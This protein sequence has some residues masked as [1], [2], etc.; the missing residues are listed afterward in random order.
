MKG[1]VIAQEVDS[2]IK[3]QS[4]L[5]LD[6]FAIRIGILSILLL[7]LYYPMIM[8]L[9][10][11]WWE[12][13]DYSH[14]F[15]V[16][17][18]SLYFAWTKKDRLASISLKPNRWGLFILLAGCGLFLLGNL[19][20]ELFLMRTSLIVVIVGIIIFLLGQ[21]F[22]K[23]LL[24]PVGFLV[25]M[26]P[27]P[28]IVFNAIAFPLQLFA[29]KTAT[30]CLQSIH[31]PVLREGNLIQL[32]TTIMDVTE[33]CSGIRSLVTLI[34]LGTLFAYIKEDTNW[35]R[36]VIIGST[37]PIAIIANAFRVTGTGILAEYIGEET[38]V[39]FYHTFSGWIVFVIAFILLLIVG[40]I[41][42]KAPDIKRTR[43]NSVTVSSRKLEQ[44]ATSRS[45]FLI[46]AALILMVILANQA[47]SHGEP[48]MLRNEFSSFPLKLGEWQGKEEH[49]EDKIVKVLGV[50]DYMTRPYTKVSETTG[51]VENL[52]LYIG[53]Y[54]SQRKG[55]TYHSPKNCLPGSG[56]EIIDTE[57][58]AVPLESIKGIK[59]KETVNKVIIQK[60][61][62]RQLI[63]YWYQDR[64]RV[65]ASEYWAKGYLVWDAMTRNRTDGSLVRITVP[66]ERGK[67]VDDAYSTAVQF[68]RE[69][70]P[71]LGAYLPD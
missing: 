18:I 40:F 48:V 70:S 10:Q 46:S 29:A 15:L 9:V 13:P 53:Y 4:S 67:P 55:A 57:Q 39:G 5:K 7:A 37:I 19:G 28:A 36:S 33:A 16:P 45:P 49:Y 24:F 22:M 20:A 23:E 38:A 21:A 34:T 52:W 69:I 41:L 54:A 56:W 60:G 47:M 62:D 25:F 17:F 12:N 64:G 59:N 43:L 71:L 32:S 11:E 6:H 30:F 44:M 66:V 50:T 1:P 42:S 31:I 58:V 61:L 27:L 14:G 68:A 51:Q 26:I 35:K 8:E 63:L 3:N 2:G 65:I